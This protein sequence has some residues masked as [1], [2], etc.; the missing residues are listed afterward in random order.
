M[1]DRLLTIWETLAPLS[2]VRRPIVLSLHDVRSAEWL[3]GLGETL[4]GAWSPIA[5]GEFVRLHR[6][7]AL[8]REHVAVTF[9]D[10]F[11]SMRTIVEPVL[12]GLEIPFTTFVCGDLLDGGPAPWFYRVERLLR[13]H[14]APRLA[15]FWRLPAAPMTSG[16]VLVN[17]LKAAPFPRIISGLEQAERTLGADPAVLREDFL[18]PADL[19]ALA[20]NPLATVGSHTMR[21]P[22]LSALSAQDQEREIAHSGEIL[23]AIVGYE[24]TL[25]AY[26]NGK[27]EDFGAATI[28]ALR[29]NGFEGAVTTVQRPV[30]LHDDPFRLPRLGVSEGD[31]VRKIRLKRA[32]PWLGRGDVLEARTRRRFA[33]TWSGP[34]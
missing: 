26:P 30:G 28:E 8:N 15:A 24:P 22:I 19:S 29:R 13:D 12:T 9:D 20:R 4:R 17:A 25:L 10:G 31:G 1:I 14:P 6:A 33:A 3:R 27:P 18:S 2:R 21:H 34:G 32:V 7:R 23:A 16:F 5:L 11:R